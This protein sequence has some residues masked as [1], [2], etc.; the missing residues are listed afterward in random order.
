MVG[1]SSSKF[2]VKISTVVGIDKVGASSEM[3]TIDEDVWNSSLSSHLLE[4]VLDVS[5]S[6]D[7]VKLLGL[8]FDSL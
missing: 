2:G 8:E 6:C 5:A 3:L 4:S 1:C 7:L